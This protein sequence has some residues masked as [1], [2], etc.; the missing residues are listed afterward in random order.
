VA[1]LDRFLVH[2]S[3]LATSPS[4]KSFIMP[5]LILDHKPISLHIYSIPDYAPL[6]LCFFPL[7]LNHSK[8][9]SLVAKIWSAWILG[10]PVYIW[11]Q[12]LILVKH[13]LTIWAK[14][15]FKSPSSS[16]S[17]L[18]SKIST[19]QLHMESSEPT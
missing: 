12:N 1:R 8:V 19:L 6:P 16:I 15:F 4:L 18:K 7:W 5:S 2:I 11:E 14:Y 17:T 3:F 13:A 10:T 9:D